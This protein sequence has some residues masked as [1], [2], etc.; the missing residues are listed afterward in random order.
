MKKK[1]KYTWWVENTKTRR[2]HKA[3]SKRQKAE[4]L[5]GFPAYT[6]H[7]AMHFGDAGYFLP[8]K[9]ACEK[10]ARPKKS[11]RPA[12]EEPAGEEEDYVFV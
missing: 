6:V 3:K 9:S 5:Q 8:A 4:M 1:G 7:S 10:H 2:K 12:E 11:T